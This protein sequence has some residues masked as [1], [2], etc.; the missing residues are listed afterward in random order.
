MFPK[1]PRPEPPRKPIAMQVVQQRVNGA[2]DTTRIV[3]PAP[4]PQTPSLKDEASSR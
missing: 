4:A 1:P 2:R 3:L